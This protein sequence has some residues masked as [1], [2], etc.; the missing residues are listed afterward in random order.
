MTTFFGT[1]QQQQQQQGL[2]GSSTTSTS[3]PLQPQA[4]LPANAFG[5]S[6]TTGTGGFTNQNFPS[7]IWLRLRLL[8]PLLLRN[9]LNSTTYPTM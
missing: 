8:D 2:F 1:A 4:T 6:T 5:A 7:K 9:Q 3:N